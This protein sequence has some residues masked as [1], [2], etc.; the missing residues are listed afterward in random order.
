MGRRSALAAG[1]ASLILATCLAL[2]VAAD[3]PPVDCIVV[4]EGNVCL[5]E[6][7]DDTSP[8]AEPERVESLPA[9]DSGAVERTCE[10]LGSEIPCASGMGI[11]ADEQQCYVQVSDPQPP[12]DSEVWDEQTDGVILDCQWSPTL[13]TVDVNNLVPSAMVN[14]PFWTPELPA[15]ADVVPSVLALQAV[16]QMRLGPPTI[17]LT[18]RS[19]GASVVGIATWLWVSD[20]GESTTGPIT[21]TATAGATTVTATAVLDSIEYD[22]G[23][24]S[25]VTCAGPDAPGTPY[26]ASYGDSDSPTCG[27]TYTETS[28]DERGGTFTI[29][30]TAFWTVTWSGGS[31][32]GE[33]PLQFTSSNQH[34][35][36]ELQAL[37]SS[38]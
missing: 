14:E 30:T 38:R 33:I 25:I 36:A 19:G 6:A 35:V 2:P 26:A 9:S 4:S 32:E 8:T 17:G 18:P 37:V 15:G 29:T 13:T 11:W 31:E 3:Q 21:R 12:P 10:N 5:V 24:G 28:A 34:E 16:E 1:A 20:P 7:S 22:M 27:H 23:E